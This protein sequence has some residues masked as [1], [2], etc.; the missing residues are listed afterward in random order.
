MPSTRSWRQLLV[1]GSAAML[2]LACTGGDD[3]TEVIVDGGQT[4]PSAVV[5]AAGGRTE[6]TSG[7]VRQSLE[8]DFSAMTG[9]FDEA[10][11]GAVA[12]AMRMEFEGT[13]TGSSIAGD[14]TLQVDGPDAEAVEE[15]SRVISTDGATYSD[16]PPFGMSFFGGDDAFDEQ[17]RS[18]AGGRTW[19]ESEAVDL[20]DAESDPSTMFGLDT[21]NQAL[22]ILGELDEVRELDPVRVDDVELARFAGRAG[23]DSMDGPNTM[24]IA[25]DDAAA[26]ARQ[27]RIEDYRDAHQWLE[28]EVLID[29]DG[30][31]R[32]LDLRSR[33]EVEEQYRECIELFG[34]GGVAMSVEFWDLGAAVEI[35]APDPA[36]V[37]PYEEQERVWADWF[38]SGFGSS[39]SAPVTGDEPSPIPPGMRA[40]YEEEL[41]AGAAE[42]GL[43]PAS[44]PSMPDDELMAAA[45]RLWD[46]QLSELE[47]EQSELEAQQ[48]EMSDPGL[49]DGDDWQFE[50][51]PE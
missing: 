38:G 17:L 2:T 36:D 14:V 50:G 45:E 27:Q 24:E 21:P 22:Q 23:V 15:R 47:A 31:V 20:D 39:Y 34:I 44:I 25:G 35:V 43:D 7:R 1:A 37:M 11:A 13:F 19:F 46:V 3:G 16:A 51:C 40:F 26:A 6:V 42:I 10:E 48:D 30:Y 8:M 29:P 9:S 32:Q 5:A 41:R 4:D 49:G 12:N 33:D 28:V 18:A